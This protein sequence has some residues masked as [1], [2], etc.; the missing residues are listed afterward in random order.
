MITVI[1]FLYSCK[2][3]SNTT[4]LN[5]NA[6]GEMRY[7]TAHYYYRELHVQVQMAAKTPNSQLHLNI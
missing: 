1:A 2:H 5:R 7:S 3:A 6:L 4:V